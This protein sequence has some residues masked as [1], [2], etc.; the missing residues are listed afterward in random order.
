MLIKKCVVLFSGKGTNLKNLLENQSELNGKLQYI[1][2]FTDN[3]D[4]PGVKIC[5]DYN[6][7]VTVGH[8]SNL[9]SDLSDFLVEQAPD[10]IV[11]AGY[12]RII[13]A[14]IVKNYKS[15]IVNIHPSLLPKY[16]GLNT[17]QKVLEN[18]DQYHGATVHFVTDILDGGPI[19]LQGKFEISEKI[20]LA[21][22]E[23]LTHKIEYKI[24]PIVI[25][26]IA[27]DIIAADGEYIRFKSKIIESPITYL[28]KNESL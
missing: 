23:N 15:K 14:S 12:M 8:G 2:A 11:L 21:D 4:A 17:Y 7:T 19:I 20:T 28:M 18:K 13:P 6:L 16:P 5:N 10:I 3:S 24:F 22:L 9:D 25:G 1:A 27:N 26:W